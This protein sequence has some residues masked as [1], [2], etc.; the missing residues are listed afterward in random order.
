[1]LKV[2]ISG[3]MCDLRS[4]FRSRPGHVEIEFDDQF[5]Q[6]EKENR[7]HLAQHA[8]KKMRRSSCSWSSTGRKSKSWLACQFTS[9]KPITNSVYSRQTQA[10][11]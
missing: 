5:A 3:K 2:V 8:T 6:L 10:G 1:M 7:T 11:L 9:I 4:L